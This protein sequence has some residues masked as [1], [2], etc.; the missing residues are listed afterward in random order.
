VVVVE[1]RTELGHHQRGMSGDRGG[2]PGHGG[3]GGETAPDLAEKE[4]KRS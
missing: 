4:A 3:G 1:V 2:C